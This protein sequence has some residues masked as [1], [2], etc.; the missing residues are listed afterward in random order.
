MLRSAVGKPLDHDPDF[1]WRGEAVTRIENL[2]DIAFALAL[3]MIISSAAPLATYRDLTGFML[4]MIPTAAAFAVTL[5]I[6]TYHYTFFR[7]YG[8]ADKTIIVLNAVLIFLVLFMAYPLRFTF[9][10][11]FAWILDSAGYLSTSAPEVLLGI[12]SLRDATKT[13]AIFAGF[14]GLI[15]AIYG[16]M[17]GNVLRKAGLLELNDR[18]LR[19]TR[20]ARLGMWLSSV[21]AF[22]VAAMALL[23]PL[24]P[25]SGCFLT[26]QRPVQLLA[27]RIAG[28]RG[29]AAVS[30]EG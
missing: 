24:G 2:S 11:F 13:I 30:S 17:Y 21:V 14:Y 23:T 18:E 6:W 20:T 15:F 8:V 25:F 27:E 5:Q 7:R 19:T 26:L 12:S 28:R 3:G 4:L 29:E 9:T 22:I 16:L 1:R 10:S